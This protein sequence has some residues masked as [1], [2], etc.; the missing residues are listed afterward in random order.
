M[1]QITGPK[2]YALP[3][4]VVR[5]EAD[6]PDNRSSQSTASI[7][8]LAGPSS[9][10]EPIENIQPAIFPESEIAADDL[11]DDELMPHFFTPDFLR[12]LPQPE[13][14]ENTDDDDFE[15]AF[16]LIPGIVPEPYWDI[17]MGQEFNYAQL[18]YYLNKAL[19]V[20]L[21]QREME[22]IQKAFRND[23]EMVLHVGMA[24]HKLADL[25]AHNHTVAQELLVCMTHTN[26]IQKYYDALQD[27]KLSSNSLEVFSKISSAVELPQEFIQIYLNKQMCECRN[28]QE[29][30][31]VQKRLVRIVSVFLT[32][33]IKA[34]IINF[35]TDMIMNIQ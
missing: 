33:L 28:S 30:K 14:I 5:D 8:E 24:P 4:P 23:Q 15:D 26:Q 32:S 1:P 10:T 3:A 9:P 11:T 18:K 6:V 27:I 29:Q 13:N 21:Q 2:A 19:K 20:P 7:S 35:N 31:G 17:N 34:K 12:P 16:W 22:H 25:I